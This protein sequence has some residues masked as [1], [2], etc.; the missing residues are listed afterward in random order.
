M[1]RRASIV[2]LP[3]GPSALDTQGPEHNGSVV[4]SSQAHGLYILWFC[5]KSL[6]CPKLRCRVHTKEPRGRCTEEP[7]LGKWEPP[8]PHVRA[9]SGPAAPTSHLTLP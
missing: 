4:S 9:V 6:F 7:N 1:F 3:S 8:N 5:Q 2:L